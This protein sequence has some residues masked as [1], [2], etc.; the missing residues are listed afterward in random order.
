MY[1]SRR[2]CC[3]SH[4]E[5]DGQ[6]SVPAG[7]VAGSRSESLGK[8]PP[9]PRGTLKPRHVDIRYEF[10]S[11][12]IPTDLK[13]SDEMNIKEITSSYFCFKVLNLP[14]HYEGAGG[15]KSS[16]GAASKRFQQVL[17]YFSGVKICWFQKLLR[18]S[19]RCKTFFST[20]WIKRQNHL[21][22][23]VSDW[24]FFLDFGKRC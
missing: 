23:L 16:K 24:L 9:E 11:S 22:L 5:F 20:E 2:S 13:W 18:K 19:A 10:A 12:R 15:V 14:D 6:S 8:A 4:L 3:C 1:D 21:T 17:K 7:E